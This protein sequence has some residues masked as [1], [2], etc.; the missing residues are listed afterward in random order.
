MNSICS[1]N[2]AIMHLLANSP[3][4][5]LA[6]LA[7]W[8]ALKWLLSGSCT[9][10]SCL[11]VALK[12]RSV[13]HVMACHE[14]G[15]DLVSSL[16]CI[17]ISGLSCPWGLLPWSATAFEKGSALLCPGWCS[18]T[19]FCSGR[20]CLICL[21]PFLLPGSSELCEPLWFTSHCVPANPVNELIA[22]NTN[23]W[24]GNDSSWEAG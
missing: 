3:N 6:P 15:A 14:S 20:T 22:V 10:L 2:R 8:A 4:F 12:A 24:T 5:L 23:S 13:T 7:P 1:S 9:P 16:F 17:Y 11:K 19:W 18:L 21:L